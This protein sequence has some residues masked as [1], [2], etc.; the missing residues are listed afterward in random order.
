[1]E[2]DLKQSRKDTAERMKRYLD[3]DQYKAFKQLQEDLHDTIVA[4]IEAAAEA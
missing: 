2:K 1:M 3:K 4:R